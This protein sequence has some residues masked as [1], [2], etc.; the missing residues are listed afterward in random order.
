M[1]TSLCQASEWGIRGLQCTFASCKRRLP[2]NKLKCKRVIESIVLTH[3]LCTDLVG[4]SQIKTV[5]DPVQYADFKEEENKAER[6]CWEYIARNLKE[7]TLKLV[8]KAN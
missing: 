4:Q 1:Y 6:Y 3:N 7:L 8:R 5:F 2:G